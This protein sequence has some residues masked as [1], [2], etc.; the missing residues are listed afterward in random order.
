MD[1]CCVTHARAAAPSRA[2]ARGC[3][4]RCE[5]L[6]DRC[7]ER[8]R[9]PGRH[10]QPRLVVPHEFGHA[11]HGGCD[12][13]QT[14]GHR[15]ENARRQAL[16]VRWVDVDIGRRE[17]RRNVRAGAEKS[18]DVGEG[19]GGGVLFERP[20]LAAVANDEAAHGRCSGCRA[21]G[22]QARHCVEQVAVSLAGA[23]HGDGDEHGRGGRD[24]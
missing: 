24:A 22:A 17:Q 20:S 14:N 1:A 16:E 21:T 13:E 18:H 23:E 4:R 11:A 2:P 6:L 5:R 3:A 10:E 19:E 15:F 8:A 12:H 9:I 7:G